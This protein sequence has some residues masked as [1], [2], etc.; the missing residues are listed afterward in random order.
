MIIG[1]QSE[2]SIIRGFVNQKWVPYSQ[3]Y[4]FNAIPDTNHTNHNANPTNPNR[5][6]KGNPNPTNLNTRY[7]ISEPSDYWTLGLSIHY[8]F[9]L[10]LIIW[11][12]TAVETWTAGRNRGGGE[13]NSSPSW[14]LYFNPWLTHCVCV[15]VCLEVDV[16]ATFFPCHVNA[17]CINNEG[18]FICQCRPGYTGDGRYC[19]GILHIPLYRR[20]NRFISF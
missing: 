19:T 16:C 11:W 5:Y 17:D 4:L 1:R 18:S 3:R 15:C 12:E 14:K 10:S 7:R 8:P 2:G 20:C 13:L 6:S 9:S